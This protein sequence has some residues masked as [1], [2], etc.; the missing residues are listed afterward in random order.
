MLSNAV[1]V[2]LN[3]EKMEGH[4]ERIAKIKPFINKKNWE[5]IIIH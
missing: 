5:G 1:T 4:P 3:L 2:A